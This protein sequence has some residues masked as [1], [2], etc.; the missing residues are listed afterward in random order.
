MREFSPDFRTDLHDLM[1][2]RRDVRHFNTTPVDAGLLHGSLQSSRLAPSVG[3]SEPWR[4]VRVSDPDTRTKATANY[5]QANL[6]DRALVA[7]LCIGWPKQ[8]TVTPELEIVGLED[9]APDPITWM[10]R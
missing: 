4:I 3:L 1:K 10:E 8:D 5:K 2:W 7:Y 9:R 6:D